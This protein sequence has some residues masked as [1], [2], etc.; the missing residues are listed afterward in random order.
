MTVKNADSNGGR[1][2]IQTHRKEV[3][4]YSHR[5]PFDHPIKHPFVK[6]SYML[7]RRLKEKLYLSLACCRNTR[8]STPHNAPINEIRLHIEHIRSKSMS[9][10]NLSAPM[11]GPLKTLAPVTAIKIHQTVPKVFNALC[12]RSLIYICF[13]G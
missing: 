11:V 6:V 12:G 10:D 5:F 9:D 8:G 1:N 7:D 3:N 2:S 13:L 4:Q